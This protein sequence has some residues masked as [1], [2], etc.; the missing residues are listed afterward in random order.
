MNLTGG[1]LTYVF[2]TLCFSFK[3]KLNKSDPRLSELYTTLVESNGLMIK[4]P[5][6]RVMDFSYVKCTI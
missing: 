6:T 2:S 5:M 1:M 3:I 4:F